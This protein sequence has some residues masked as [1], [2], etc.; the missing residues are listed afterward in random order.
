M[1]HYFW[2]VVRGA[3]WFFFRL[4]REEMKSECGGFDQGLSGSAPPRGKSLA[5]RSS[6]LQRWW[7]AGGSPVGRLVSVWVCGRSSSSKEK[8]EARQTHSRGSDQNAVH[9][10]DPRRFSQRTGTGRVFFHYCLPLKMTSWSLFTTSAF[11]FC[12]PAS[13]LSGKSAADLAFNC[14]PAVVIPA[15]S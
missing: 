4:V 15:T 10:S 13:V 9:V 14:I 2:R 1:E 12:N 3:Q 7:T 11:S 6:S 8:E 5:H